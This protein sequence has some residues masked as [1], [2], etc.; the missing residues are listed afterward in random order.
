MATAQGENPV[1]CGKHV[2]EEGEAGESLAFPEHFPM[3]SAGMGTAQHG[4]A[5]AQP[6]CL[7]PSMEA[8]PAP[9]RIQALCLANKRHS[10]G[11]HHKLHAPNFTLLHKPN[12]SHVKARA[13]RQ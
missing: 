13:A 5:A 4:L 6:E 2:W 12:C 3:H 7:T 10:P 8:V 9:S 11:N 1:V